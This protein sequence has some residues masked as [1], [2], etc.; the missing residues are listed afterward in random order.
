MTDPVSLLNH[1][2]FVQFWIA[3]VGSIL[4]LQMVSVAVGWQIYNLTNNPLDLGLVGLAQFAPALVLLLFVGHVA[5]RYDRARIISAAQAVSATVT[6]MLALASG[7]GWMTR[8]LFLLAMFALG[9]ARAFEQP[10]MQALL[11]NLV[12]SALLPR[13]VAASSSATQAA[14]ILGPAVGGGLIYLS[15]PTLAYLVCVILFV[16]SSVLSLRLVVPQQPQESGKQD[17]GNQDAAKRPRLTPE[18]L[19]AGIAYI[20]KN[21]IVLGAISLDMFAVFLGGATA[22]M[23]IYARD[24]LHVGPEGLGLLRAAPGFGALAM[25]LVMARWIP[26]TGVGHKMFAAVTAFGIATV[27]FG[28]STSFIL[29]ICALVV[30][31]SMDMVS[32]VFRMSLVQLHTPDEMRGRVSAVNSLFVGASNQLGD[33]RA[34]V[35]AALFGAVPAVLIGGVGILA[36]VAIWIKVFPALYHVERLEPQK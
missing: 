25:S 7:G 27:A 16:T 20:R 22:L 30:L 1:R 31:G 10:T 28:L 19:F 3:R 29:S 8:E 4:S 5:D 36:V 34:G 24:I 9:C 17:A 12:P 2:P 23:P 21:P 13:A 11:P 18:T 6:A 14:T 32:V 15:G 33:F 26:S 35:S